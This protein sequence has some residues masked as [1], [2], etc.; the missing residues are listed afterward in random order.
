MSTRLN[1]LVLL[2][3]EAEVLLRE[4]LKRLGDEKPSLGECTETRQVLANLCDKQGKKA[5]ADELRK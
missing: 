1:F 4:N 5:E 2:V 3:Q